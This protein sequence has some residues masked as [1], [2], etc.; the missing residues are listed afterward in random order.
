VKAHVPSAF[1]NA[2]TDTYWLGADDPLASTLDR[3]ERYAAAG[4][5]GIFVPGIDAAADIAAVTRQI[6]L[7][8]NVLYLPGRLTIERLAE[9]GV[10]RVSTGS[11]LYREALHAAVL[12]A[13]AIRGDEAEPHVPMYQQVQ[14]LVAQF[15]P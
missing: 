2:R 15:Q 4:A 11:L 10:A 8:L 3:A 6:P 12:S 14:A 1:V 5:D 9:L 13:R 7:P